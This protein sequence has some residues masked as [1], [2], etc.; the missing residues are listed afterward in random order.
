MRN[1]STNQSGKILATSEDFVPTAYNL[2]GQPPESGPVDWQIAM[3]R[4]IRSSRELREAVGL[5]P[6]ASDTPGPDGKLR[7]EHDFRTFAPLEFVS[8]IRPG[9]PDDPLLRQVLPILDE[10]IEQAG[11]GSDP[12]GDLNALAAPGVLHKYEGRALV[13]TTAACGIHCRY[14]FRREFPYQETGSRSDDWRPSIDYLESNPDIEE[15]ILSGGDPLTTTDEKLHELLTAIENIRHVQRLRIH[16]RMPIVIPQRLTDS[17]VNRLSESRLAVWLVIHTNHPQ[18]LSDAV[19]SRLA[20]AIDS[21]IPVLN[22]AVLLRGVNDNADT[23]IQLFRRLV[24]HRI[25]PYYLHQLDQVR[26]AA[27]F[28]VPVET[29]LR[30]LDTL[31]AALPGYAVP[32]YVFEEAGAKSKLPISDSSTTVTSQASSDSN[33]RI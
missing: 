20:A 14:C 9:D 17:L 11:F 18:E 32:Q 21:G 8:R 7:C 1:E 27:H 26:G 16:S 33:V 23:L 10:E 31:R 3:K 25:Q 29:G 30:L 2:P 12:V 5:P 4:A 6:N 22:Q 13:L 19:L 28:E 15:V 24:N